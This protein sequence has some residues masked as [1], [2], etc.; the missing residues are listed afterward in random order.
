M[1]V[2]LYAYTCGYLTSFMLEGEKGAIPTSGRPFPRPRCGW[3]DIEDE[4]PR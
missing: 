4:A 3:A 2:K 1:S